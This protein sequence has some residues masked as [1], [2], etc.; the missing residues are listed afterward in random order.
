ML[1]FDHWQEIFQTLRRN[2][3]RAA[4]TGLSVA[5]GILMLIV[6]LGAGQ[7]L[8]NQVES[9]FEDDATN[10]I[11]VRPGKTALP[12]MG[13]RPGRQVKFTNDDYEAVKRIPG[14]EHAS[15]RFYMHGV[16][17]TV[18]YG[19]KSASFDAR[20]VHPGHQYLE[21]TVITSG[22]YLNEQDIDQQRKVA[23]IGAPVAT[24]FFG[25]DD[26]LG[27]YLTVRGIQYKIVGTF[28]DDGGEGE[29]QKI[30]LPVTTA[31][32]AYNAHGE[33]HHLL[34]TVGDASVEQSRLIEERVREVLAERLHFDAKDAGALRMRNNVEDF[35][36]IR[37]VFALIRTFLWIVGLGTITASI[38]GVSNILLI[39]VAERTVEI[40][41]RKALGATPFSIVSMI[42]KESLLVTGLAG[43]LGLFAGIALLELFNSVL[44]AN[45]YIKNPSVDLSVAI[46]ALVILVVS[47]MIAG[48]IPASRA[49]SV[50]PVVALRSE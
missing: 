26:P 6:L 48:F 30:Y 42:L 32:R 18:N 22:R 44:P 37:Q 35:H 14:V 50:S 45:D 10:S 4:L 23:V 9:N 28:I 20:S 39:S 25:N 2:K 38:I 8:Q 13:L 43:Y 36:K 16:T 15:G 1:F 29:L 12:F 33:L 49:A 47:G 40:G 3:M 5:W 17:Y 19:T 24:F 41:V 31:Q 11:W 34:F 7:G 27:E 21:K 46:T